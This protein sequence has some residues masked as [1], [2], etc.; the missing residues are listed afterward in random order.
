[1]AAT[2]Q[3]ERFCYYAI[4]E[5]AEKRC[6]MVTPLE[7]S[8]HWHFILMRTVQEYAEIQGTSVCVCRGK[9]RDFK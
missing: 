6:V 7:V 3:I 2:N 4:V 9:I 1:M 5:R 8:V